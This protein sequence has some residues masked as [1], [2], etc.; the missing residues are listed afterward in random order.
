LVD[1][2]T[3]SLPQQQHHHQQ[4]PIVDSLPLPPTGALPGI[5][6]WGTKEKI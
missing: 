3:Q 4:Q 1:H 2:V 5:L 6:L